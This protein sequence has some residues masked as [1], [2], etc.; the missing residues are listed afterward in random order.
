M[1]SFNTATTMAEPKVFINDQNFINQISTES[2][3]TENVMNAESDTL[4]QAQDMMIDQLL[5]DSNENLENQ[6]DPAKDLYTNST[7]EQHVESPT[8]RE[9]FTFKCVFCDRV[10]NANDDPKLL[11]CLHNSCS[12]CINSKLYEHNDGMATGK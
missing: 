12:S 2:Q 11:E 8:T 1:T 9:S 5:S 4:T 6:K 3:L 10:L 7:E